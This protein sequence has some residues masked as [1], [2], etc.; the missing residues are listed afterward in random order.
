M[1]S[2]EGFCCLSASQYFFLHFSVG[3]TISTQIKMHTFRLVLADY[4]SSAATAFQHRH[5][6]LVSD[7]SKINTIH[8]PQ[9]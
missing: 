3:E 5:C 1:T 4:L 8:L 9:W 2:G 6:M 7:T